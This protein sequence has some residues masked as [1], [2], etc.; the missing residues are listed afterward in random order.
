MQHNPSATALDCDRRGA[1]AR[2]APLRPGAVA[3]LAVLLAIAS[4]GGPSAAPPGAPAGSGALQT[5]PLPSGPTAYEGSPAAPL[6]VRAGAHP[7]GGAGLWP[8][9][10]PPAGAGPSLGASQAAL[11]DTDDDD[12]TVSRSELPPVEYLT[13]TVGGDPA[14]LAYRELSPTGPVL[15]RTVLIL[16][17][18]RAEGDRPTVGRRD[19]PNWSSVALGL[20]AEGYRVLLDYGLEGA[21]AAPPPPSALQVEHTRLLLDS[22]GAPIVAIIAGESRGQL[23]AALTDR[24]PERVAGVLVVPT[25]VEARGAELAVILDSW[26]EE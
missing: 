4:A 11:P 23:A 1:P 22:L 8:G 17:D 7:D 5:P 12:E 13:V 2:R 21:P 10:G 3:A 16:P 14:L 24:L 6:L 9:G 25:A 26:L 18:S 20:A 15:G 19:D